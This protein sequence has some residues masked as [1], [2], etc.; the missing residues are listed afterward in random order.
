MANFN[1]YVNRQGI[2]GRKGE[3]G[4]QGF[5]PIISVKTQT[6]NEYVLTVQNEDGS[7][8]SPNLRGNAITNNGGTYI[9]YNPDTEEMYT[10]YADVASYDRAGEVQFA[11]YAQ[12]ENGGAEQLGVTSMDVHDFVNAKISEVDAFTFD[13]LAN[14]LIGGSNVTLTVD[15]ENKTITI[16]SN[17]DTSDCIKY[18][19]I[20]TEITS[21]S[22]DDEVSSAKAV[23][24]IVQSSIPDLSNYVDLTSTQTIS[25]WKTFTSQ[26]NFNA[27]IQIP[28]D[29]NRGITFWNYSGNY[30]QGHIKFRTLSNRILEIRNYNSVNCQLFFED[31]YKSVYLKD[32]ATM[33]DIPSTTN[34]AD[35]DLA[36]LSTN[37]NNKLHA[38][39]GYMD[40]L[41]PLNDSEGYNDYVNNL[42]STFDRSKFSVVGSPNITDDGVAS[43]FSN[44]TF[45]K[46]ASAIT[47]TNNIVIKGSFTTP[48][49][50]VNGNILGGQ[51]N[52]Y[53]GL[54]I[55]SSKLLLSIGN[56]SSWI[57]NQVSGSTILTA[58]TTYYY[59][60]TFDGTTYKL[61]LSTD[62]SNLILDIT[63]NSSQI[64]PSCVLYFGVGRTG[65]SS[66]GGSI[67]LK[68][69]SI[70]VDGVEVFSGNKTG[71]DVI[72]PDN[73]TVVGS[74][75]ITDGV[76]SG[77][78]ARNYLKTPAISFPSGSAW[79]MDIQFNSSDVTTR[80]QQLLHY[81]LYNR[82]LINTSG[83][84]IIF[85][86]GNLSLTFFDS[87]D[88]ATNTNYNLNILYNG[89]NTYTATLT[90]LDT[91]TSKTSTGTMA[92]TFPSEPTVYNIGS[93]GDRYFSG[94][95][96]LKNFSIVSGNNGIYFPYLQIPYTETK[97]GDRLSDIQYLP[98]A[99]Y[100][101]SL[102]GNCNEVILNQASQVYYLPAGSV[103]GKI[104]RLNNSIGD[105]SAILDSINGEAI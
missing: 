50:I 9:R 55:S 17:T 78:S 77:F 103:Y 102:T 25:G 38:L 62:N 89:T 19:D 100:G 43:G 71:I 90:N 32:I 82:V 92:T 99:N 59:K 61:Y 39:K 66:F 15:D 49:S 98:R 18:S 24:D 14:T 94:T 68:Y 20:S 83:Q 54:E 91:H 67:D 48:A 51:T 34:L 23:Y 84:V 3:Q 85:A 65:T 4:E 31:D 76:V 86:G 7:F 6:A 1:F 22:T 47:F 26:Q 60:I 10:G 69:F 16:N 46:T 33:S 27:G 75:T 74:L 64:I 42:H 56:G 53:I 40:E 36:N 52:Q 41:E 87:G 73:Y 45:V 88:I 70:T 79:T 2:R 97:Q 21:S 44:N 35:K 72:E 101:Y 95:I 63:A 8:D 13:K 93:E 58:S 11:T 104:N 28:A 29:T 30:V 12:L 81:N 80:L 96:N 105:I 5:S 57:V 37:G